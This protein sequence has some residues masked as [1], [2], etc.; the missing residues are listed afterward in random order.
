MVILNRLLSTQQIMNELMLIY[1]NFNFLKLNDSFYLK[2]IK[3]GN[4]S[5]NCFKIAL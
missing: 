2:K 3:T 1:T 5:Q 4:K